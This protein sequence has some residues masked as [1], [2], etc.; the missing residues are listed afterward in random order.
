MIFTRRCPPASSEATELTT[1]VLEM[2][3]SLLAAEEAFERR[4]M[5]TQLGNASKDRTMRKCGGTVLVLRETGVGGG[6]MWLSTLVRYEYFQ[7][8]SHPRTL[9]R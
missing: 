2:P 1:D 4:H 9:F 5:E 7:F 3:E 8:Y 6:E